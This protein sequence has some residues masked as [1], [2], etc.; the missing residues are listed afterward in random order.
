M[1]KNQLSPDLRVRIKQTPPA[2]TSAMA[3]VLIELGS[4]AT[5]PRDKAVWVEAMRVLLIAGGRDGN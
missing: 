5:N 2:G 1:S 4:E 3:E